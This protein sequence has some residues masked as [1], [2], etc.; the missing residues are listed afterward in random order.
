MYG[1][2]KISLVNITKT[3]PNIRYPKTIASFHPSDTYA[4]TASV[5]ITFIDAYGKAKSYSIFAL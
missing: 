5:I 2:K 3:V 4:P 1:I